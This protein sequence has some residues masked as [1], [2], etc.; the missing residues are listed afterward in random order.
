MAPFVADFFL[1]RVPSDYSPE[2][3]GFCEK[4]LVFSFLVLGYFLPYFYL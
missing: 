2:Y 1:P 4:G 3:V